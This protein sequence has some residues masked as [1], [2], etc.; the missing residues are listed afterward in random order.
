[1]ALQVEYFGVA[2]KDYTDIEN[3]AIYEATAGRTLF[4]FVYQIGRVHVWRNG[5]KIP[6][7]HFTAANGTSITL[8]DPCVEGETIELMSR[9]QRPVSDVY[10]KLS[11]E[12]LANTY[13]L[14]ATGTGDAAAGNV[15]TL[16][17]FDLI[18]GR[19]VRVRWP[20]S[21]TVTNP[22]LN[23]NRT[24]NITVVASGGSPVEIGA[25]ATGKEIVVRYKSAT[26]VFEI[27][28]LVATYPT[29]ALGTSN[30]FLANT[31]FVQNGLNNLSLQ[32]APPSEIAYFARSS[33]PTGW[34][35]ANGALLSRTTYANLFAAIGTTFGAGDGSTTFAI[36]DLRGEFIRGWDDA[37]GVDASRNFGSWQGYA[38]EAH[39][40]PPPAGYSYVTST[41]MTT[42]GPID[43]STTV[44]GYDRDL[45]TANS[46]SY[47]SN[48]TRPRNVALL[49]CIKY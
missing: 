39:T 21:N 45:G 12:S 40:H 49:A 41:T 48:E 47:G 4:P 35:K 19:E 30:T 14:I 36:P 26:N 1:M 16:S 44:T 6:P 42:D 17:F 8:T 27:T 34:I 29:L 2:P 9:S 43:G 28:N 32:V 37:R 18:D 20:G 25:L 38:V 31:Q 13:F 46:G 24:G 23:V 22:T 7:Y 3:Y 33:A 10:T 15:E 11:I 5:V